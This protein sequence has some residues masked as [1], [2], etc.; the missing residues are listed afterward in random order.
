M[1]DDLNK[2]AAL[3]GRLGGKS[4]SEAK[5]RAARMN[6]KKGGRP[7][8][9]KDK[10]KSQPEPEHEH[11]MKETI[12][13]LPGKAQIE[14]RCEQDLVTVSHGFI[15]LHEAQE[16]L[17]K[18]A[19][20]EEGWGSNGTCPTCQSKLNADQVEVEKSDNERKTENTL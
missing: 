20:L 12:Y 5:R 7:K 19:E 8:K 11:T 6:G 4:T 14:C 1:S 2:A 10:D 16:K 3:L 15:P 18:T 17:E 13:L 9:N